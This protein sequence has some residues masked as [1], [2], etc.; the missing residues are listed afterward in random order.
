MKEK[1]VLI[2]G[3]S[4]GLG[5][6][7]AL[8][9]AHNKYNV[10]LH[11]RN[12]QRLEKAKRSVLA[13]GVECDVVRGDITDEATI[14][15]LYNAAQRRNIDVLINNAGTY[16]NKSFE[17]MEI[18]EFRRLIEINLI[19]PVVL[20]K[21]IFPIFKKKSKGL[22]IYINSFAG[23]IP[24]DGECAYCASKHGLR[25]FTGS[26]QFD[27]TR[28]NIRLIDVY[29]GAMK[30]DMTKHRTNS[31]NFIET[32]DVADLILQLSKNY[33]SMRI[34]EIDLGRRKY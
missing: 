30:T 25:G 5:K 20:T 19:S 14:D 29:L 17:K 7:M 10:I 16:V 1:T 13:N 27:A 26:L 23:K 9:F 21:R 3:S 28:N 8:V 22:I 34:N 18:D 31:E 2:T 12:E 4:K 24:S 15:S 11:G 33:S 6:T 32:S